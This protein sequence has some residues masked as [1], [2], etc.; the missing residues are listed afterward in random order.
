[1]GDLVAIHARLA[2]LASPYGD[3]TAG[4]QT[5]AAIAALAG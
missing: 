5:A 1:M 3:G 2:G 4:A